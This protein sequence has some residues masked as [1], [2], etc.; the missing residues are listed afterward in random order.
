MTGYYY[1][2]V[3]SSIKPEYIALWSERTVVSVILVSGQTDML[4]APN[5]GLYMRAK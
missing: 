3:M 5:H 1:N 2:D 4:I